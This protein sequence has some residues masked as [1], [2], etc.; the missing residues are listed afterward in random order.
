MLPSTV[1]KPSFPYSFSVS[2]GTSVTV[3]G[4]LEASPGKEQSV[5]MQLEKLEVLGTC[6]PTTYPVQPKHHTP[7]FL[8]EISHLRP[9]T[10]MFAATL[11]VRSATSHAI[12]RF[13]E[14]SLLVD[15]SVHITSSNA[16]L[17]K[18][19]HHY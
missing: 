2:V 12:H 11:R 7:E 18:Y 16:I 4:R 17:H 8:R 10:Q 19:I 6:D 5:E 3:R 13:F 1:F 9:K 15:L 14:V